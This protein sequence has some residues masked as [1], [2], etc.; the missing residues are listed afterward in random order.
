LL[1]T[2]SFGTLSACSGQVQMRVPST[3]RKSQEAA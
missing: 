3:R 1:R 2:G